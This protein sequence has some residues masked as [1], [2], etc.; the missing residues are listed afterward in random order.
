MM[1]T[2]EFFRLAKWVR[3]I[4]EVKNVYDTIVSCVITLILS[5][6]SLFTLHSSLFSF[7]F[8]PQFESVDARVSWLLREHAVKIGFRIAGL[9][10]DDIEYLVYTLDWLENNKNVTDFSNIEKCAILVHYAKQLLTEAEHVLGI[11]R[12]KRLKAKLLFTQEVVLEGHL[13]QHRAQHQRQHQHQHQHHQSNNISNNDTNSDAFDP[14][15]IFASRTVPDS[16]RIAEFVDFSSPPVKNTTT[17]DNRIDGQSSHNLKNKNGNTAD[18]QLQ[19]HCLGDPGGPSDLLHSPW[20]IG[21][22]LFTVAAL[23][24]TAKA[25]ESLSKQETL[26]LFQYANHAIEL[27]ST[28]YQT[29][30]MNF[31]DSLYE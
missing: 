28:L 18:F 23:V 20:A 30:K 16:T 1:P 2:R 24:D 5:T 3:I 22:S 4:L 27:L 6:F 21:E 11:E 29:R 25:I 7:L 12:N 17:T 13:H 19:R 26:K 14:D 15:L 31:R 10:K 8:F 9:C